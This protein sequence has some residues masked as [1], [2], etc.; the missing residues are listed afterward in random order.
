[1]AE[2]RPP[3]RPLSAATLCAQALGHQ[4]GPLA[5]PPAVVAPIDVATTYIRDPDNQYRSGYAYGRPDNRT[6]RQA[7]ALIARLEGAEQALVLGSGMSAAIAVFFALAPGDHI[8]A[9]KVMYWGLRR[10]L[11]GEARRWG[12]AVD[13][14]DTS[15]RNELRGALQPGRT[16]LVWLET[17]ANPLWTITDIAAAADLAHAAGARL[18]V[19]FH[20]FDADLEPPAGARCRYRHACG[21]QISERS[22]RR[23]CRR[24]GLRPSR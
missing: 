7:E 21:H 19:D 15:D 23:R 2:A 16:K 6:I 22:F 1:M 12:L 13:L 3:P 14:I 5:E 18:A 10:W 17:P 24:L 11:N 8:V 9:P 4:A 20:R